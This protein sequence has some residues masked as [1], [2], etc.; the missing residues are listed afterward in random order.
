[1]EFT[2][3]IK[4]G[5]A[6]IRRKYNAADEG[7]LEDTLLSQNVKVVELR[8][9]NLNTKR[10]HV[11]KKYILQL[12][13]KM[14]ICYGINMPI[15]D[16]L[17]LCQSVI[18]NKNLKLTLKEIREKVAAG[19]NI[20]SCLWEYPNIFPPVICRLIEVGYNS[21]KMKEACS[22]I[23][24]ML[25]IA[26]HTRRKIVSA[27]Y[28]PGMVF[29][30][31]VFAVY[32]LITK[33]IPTFVTLFQ[34]AGIALPLPTRML[35]AITNTLTAQPLV[36]FLCV[37]GIIGGILSLPKLYAHSYL[38]QKLMLHIFPFGSLLNYSQRLTTVSTLY[39]ILEAQVPMLN[40]LRMTR[41]AVSNIRF[42]EAL[43]D[44]IDSVN[45]GSGLSEGLESH[46][47]LLTPELVK[48]LKFAEETGATVQIL[49][50]LQKEYEE[51]LEYQI[52]LF[53]EAIQPVITVIIAV[54]VLFILLALFLP[55]FNMT[56]VIGK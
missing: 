39:T 54:V 16:T 53:K 29:I 56:Q 41:N 25:N 24:Y 6:F 37:M 34:G 55:M 18:P 28:Y 36:T 38:F 42:K 17:E 45:K 9:K 14:R 44:A 20:A 1:M 48:S 4:K 3:I 40:A 26:A 30:A 50:S 21:G 11:P 10:R 12:F 19:V 22:K 15:L 8:Q 27:M 43:V 33:T 51:G 7:T 49:E 5:N 46:S 13:A 52:S 35:V 47:D 31:L 32:V 2:G 23:F